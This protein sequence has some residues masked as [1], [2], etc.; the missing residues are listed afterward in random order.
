MTD[1]YNMK[2]AQAELTKLCRSGK[3]FVIS[4]RNKPVVVALPVD[5]FEALMETLEILGDPKAMKAINS[6]RAD[7]SNYRDL[8]LDDE[9]LGL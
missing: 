9:N 7:E 1:T 5:D 8:D 3:R 2:Q 4:N 6:A